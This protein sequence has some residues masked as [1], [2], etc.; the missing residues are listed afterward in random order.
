MDEERAKKGKLSFGRTMLSVLQAGFGVQSRA[1][2][3]RDFANG[4]AATFI[5]A[6]LIF[7][8][9]FVLTLVFVVRS[10]LP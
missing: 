4:S 10:V 6:A 2:R 1:N 5:A 8:A 9:L 3:E 7:A